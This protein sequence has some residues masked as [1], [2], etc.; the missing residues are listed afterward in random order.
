MVQRVHGIGRYIGMRTLEIDGMHR[1]YVTIQ[2]A[3][4]DK[5]Y[6]PMEQITTLEKYIGPEGQSPVLSKMGGASWEKSG[7]KQSSP[8]RNWRNDF[9]RYMPKEKLLRALP[10]IRIRRNR[11]NLK[12]PFPM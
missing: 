1:D 3:G 7:A 2:Y 9:W 5:L 8:F 12:I 10:L 11:E 4:G 6:L